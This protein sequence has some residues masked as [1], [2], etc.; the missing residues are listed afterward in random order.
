M[1]GSLKPHDSFCGISQRT[2]SYFCLF[3][4]FRKAETFPFAAAVSEARHPWAPTW[5]DVVEL[6]LY[7]LLGGG[8]HEVPHVE[9][10]H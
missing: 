3:W 6:L 7:G 1:G 10:F 4:R 5:L 9:D 2:N 8:E